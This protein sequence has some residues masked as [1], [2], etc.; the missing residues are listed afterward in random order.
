[1]QT[2]CIFTCFW[3]KWHLPMVSKIFT[4][5]MLDRSTLLNCKT[6]SLLRIV[7]EQTVKC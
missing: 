1:M 6:L 5:L 4:V 2:I 7:N 3:F